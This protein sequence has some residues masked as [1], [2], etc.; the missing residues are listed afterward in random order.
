MA[1]SWRI[2]LKDRLFSTGSLQ[3]FVDEHNEPL[4]KEAERVDEEDARRA[5]Q[6]GLPPIWRCNRTQVQRK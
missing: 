3:S 4:L 2:V 5:R 1:D 6:E